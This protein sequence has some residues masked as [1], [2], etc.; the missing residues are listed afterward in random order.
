MAPYPEHENSAYAHLAKFVRNAPDRQTH[1]IWRV[2]AEALE[3]H[4]GT[5]PVWLSTA[6]L[7]VYWLHIRLD[8]RPKYYR[9]RP[10]MVPEFWSNRS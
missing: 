6:G 10:Y 3:G 8:S 4:I 2:V 1:E 9:H 7:G 5:A